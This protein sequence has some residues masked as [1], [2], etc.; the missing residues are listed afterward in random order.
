LDK[1]G[2]SFKSEALELVMPKQQ[3][4][5][6]FDIFR[7]TFETLEVTFFKVVPIWAL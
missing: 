7:A 6:F 4:K 1:S 3:K 2:W 5:M